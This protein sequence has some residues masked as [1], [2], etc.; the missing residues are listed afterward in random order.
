ME[1][2]RY[3]ATRSAVLPPIAASFYEYVF[4]EN[5]VYIRA[6]R[7]EFEAFVPVT[8]CQIRGLAA[9]EPYFHFNLPRV[10]ALITSEILERSLSATNSEGKLLEILFH[11]CWDGKS[12]RLE[13]PQQVQ[14]HCRCK[15][16][17][18]GASSSYER[19]SIEIHSHHVMSTH[20]SS[21]DDADETGLRLYGII[22]RLTQQ[23]EFRLRVGVYCN[24]L[25][26]PANWV[27]ELPQTIVNAT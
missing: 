1:L 10:P 14:G 11:V 15:P 19:A 16:I 4:A 18:C 24:Y 21:T 3:I 13:V 17:D 8:N 7:P 9:V 26:I 27:F 25:E 12:W 6:K 20:Y 23:P 22:G 5:G 2:V